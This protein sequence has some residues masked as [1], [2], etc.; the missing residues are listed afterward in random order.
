MSQEACAAQSLLNGDSERITR[1]G[2]VYVGENTDASTAPQQT[3]ALPRRR[4]HFLVGALF[5][6][7]L[8]AGAFVLLGRLTSTT[9]KLRQLEVTSRLP[10]SQDEIIGASDL[11][12]VTTDAESETGCKLQKLRDEEGDCGGNDVHGKS[13]H[14]GSASKCL[15]RCLDVA[16]C[17][18]FIYWPGKARSEHDCYPKRICN[19]NTGGGQAYAYTARSCAQFHDEAS[20]G[21]Y[22]CPPYTP[23]NSC[24]CNDGCERHNNCCTDYATCHF[25]VTVAAATTTP[26]TTVPPTTASEDENRETRTEASD[27]VDGSA[28]AHEEPTDIEAVETTADP[29][30]NT[31]TTWTP[32]MPEI[33]DDETVVYPKVSAT[34]S[35]GQKTQ[36]F[37]MYRA[38]DNDEY[39]LINFNAADLAGVM[40]YLHHEVVM[41]CPRKFNV[42]RIRRL[43]VTVQNTCNLKKIEGSQF[44]PYVSFDQGRCTIGGCQHFWD[45]YGF[46]VGC[47]H[48]PYNQGMWAAY[49]TP[50]PDGKCHRA[51]WYSLPGPC[52]T[53]TRWYKSPECLAQNPGGNCNTSGHSGDPTG[54]R[55]CTYQLE[56]D[57]GEVYLDELYNWD[58]N[59]WQ[60]HNMEY[61]NV[62]DTGANDAGGERVTFWQGIYEP[63][64]CLNRVKAVQDKFKEKYPHM[65]YQIAQPDCDWYKADPGD[66][67]HRTGSG[68]PRQPGDTHR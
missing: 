51:H 19:S 7:P 29:A 58:Y 44:G 8:L 13:L 55:D 15:E 53:G 24:Q 41:V 9:F 61:N 63:D 18:F 45:S 1:G 3:E 28:L 49:C 50:Q 20:C 40:W 46:V 39:P 65:P 12:I 25:A 62:T 14:T 68:Y 36:S 22:G 47:Q 56:E 33:S 5:L 26:I 4:K 54:A 43:K 57:A 27:D 21:A 34:S 16:G 67:L 2:Y 11:G 59:C 32:F 42:T 66:F 48:I 38:Q 6:S 60:G 23:G 30:M 37:Y 64:K 35:C 31:T 17:K 52:P 10:I